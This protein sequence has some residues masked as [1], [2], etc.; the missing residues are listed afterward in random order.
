LLSA[1][2][3]AALVAAA[4]WSLA[5]WLPQPPERVRMH[6][7]TSTVSTTSEVNAG[8]SNSVPLSPRLTFIEP[9]IDTTWQSTM[10]G[11]DSGDLTTGDR[12]QNVSLQEL[13]GG[14]TVVQLDLPPPTGGWSR[15][16]STEG[17]ELPPSVPPELVP[18]Q[19]ARWNLVFAVPAEGGYP[20]TLTGLG[21]ADPDL[22][23]WLADWLRGV[24]FPVSLDGDPYLVRWTLILD[25]GRPE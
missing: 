7:G 11:V 14:V 17:H 18:A 24:T 15:Q 5:N 1:M 19:G 12:N 21:A 20:L 10:A 9:K 8:T 4:L 25:V 6:L 13:L 23:R 16:S 2:A 22:D 3:H